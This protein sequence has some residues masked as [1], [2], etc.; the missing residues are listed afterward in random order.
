MR[1][2]GDHYKELKIAYAEDLKNMTPEQK[3]AMKE[4]FYLGAARV[5]KIITRGIPEMEGSME[6]KFRA[7]TQLSEDIDEVLISKLFDM[8]GIKDFINNQKNK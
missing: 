8:S 6:D 3:A 4:M 7:M 2:I 1:R 5:F